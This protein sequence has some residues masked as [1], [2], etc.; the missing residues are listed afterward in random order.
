[1]SSYGGPTERGRVSL[2]HFLPGWAA[3]KTPT[4]ESET[5]V[6]FLAQQ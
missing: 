4:R 3:G 1:M 2:S 5:Q 6:P